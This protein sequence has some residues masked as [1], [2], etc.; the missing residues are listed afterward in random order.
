VP[1]RVRLE[2]RSRDGSRRVLETALINTGFTSNSPDL[3]LPIAI[4]ERLGLWPAPAR[5]SL[6]LSRLVVELWRAT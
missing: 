6:Y 3:A 4:A 1:V 2:I 5:R